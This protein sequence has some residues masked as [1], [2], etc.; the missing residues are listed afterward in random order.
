VRDDF[1]LNSRTLLR[2]LERTAA[3]Y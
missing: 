3:C 1:V 2:V